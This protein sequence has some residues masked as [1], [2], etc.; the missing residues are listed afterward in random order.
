MQSFNLSDT[1]QSERESHKMQ[2]ENG[3]KSRRG[4]WDEYLHNMILEDAE[5]LLQRPQVKVLICQI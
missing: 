5:T 2:I 3:A 1:H 4:E